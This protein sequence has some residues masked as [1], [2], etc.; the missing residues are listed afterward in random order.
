MLPDI[1]VTVLDNP[2][3]DPKLFTITVANTEDIWPGDQVVL[4]LP[5]LDIQTIAEAHPEDDDSWMPFSLLNSYTVF[6]TDI[7]GLETVTSVDVPIDYELENLKE[8]KFEIPEDTQ[9]GNYRVRGGYVW[10]MYGPV[11]WKKVTYYHK[12]KIPDITIEVKEAVP[13]QVHGVA[14][15]QSETLKN[16]LEEALGKGPDYTGELTVVELKTLTGALDLSGAGITDADMELMQYLIGVT[17]I[18]LSDNPDITP[19]T[20]KKATFDWTLEKSLD[21]SGCTGL[22][23]LS[24]RAFYGCAGLKGFVFPNTLTA[25]GEMC[26]AGCTGLTAV[27]LPPDLTNIGDYAFAGSAITQITIPGGV[28]D[29]GE[30]VFRFCENLQTVGLPANL[31]IIGDDCFAYCRGLSDIILSTSLTSIGANCFTQCESLTELILPDSLTTVGAYAFS[32]CPELPLINLPAALGTISNAAF[33]SQ[34]FKVVDGRQSHLTRD[35]LSLY[36]DTVFLTGDDAGID[37]PTAEIAAGQG[38]VTLTHQ[39]PATEI[40]VWG[41]SDTGIAEVENGVVTGVSGGTAY[42]YVKSTTDSHGGYCRVTVTDSGG[43]TLSALELSGIALNGTFDPLT[44]VYT[45][46]IAGDVRSTVVALQKSD[47]GSTVQ[48][49]DAAVTPGAAATVALDYP[50]SVIEIKVTSADTAVTKTYVITITMSPVT[51]KEDGR[52]AIGNPVLKDRLALAAGKEA[53]KYTEN[54]TVTEL[55]DITG[56][57]DLSSADLLDSDMAAMQ[58][59]TG[60]SAIDFSDNTGLTVIPSQDNFD[61]T[62]EKS[63]DFSGCIGV[64]GFHDGDTSAHSGFQGVANLTGIMLPETMSHISSA[65]FRDCTKLAHVV[66]PGALKSTGSRAFYGCSTLSRIDLPEG[67]ETLGDSCFAGTGLKSIVLPS[68]LISIGNQC[69]ADCEQLI[70][71]TIPA[72]VTEIKYGGFK[73]SGLALLDLRQTAFTETDTE[74]WSIP[75]TTLVVYPGSTSAGMNTSSA[76]LTV[77]EEGLTLSHTIPDG[78]TVVWSSTDEDVAVVSADGLVTGVGAG[79]AIILVSSEDGTYFDY[80]RVTFT[81]T[82][83][84]G[85]TDLFLTG[86]NLDQ[87]FDPQRVYYTAG[88]DY[89]TP[90][91][92]TATT[93]DPSSTITVNGS[94]VNS[95]T[96]SD[97]VDLSGGETTFTVAVTT[98]GRTRAYTIVV[99]LKA[100]YEA[101]TGVSIVNVAFMHSLA[102]AAGKGADYSGPLTY[103]ELAAIQFDL[104][105]S[106]LDLSDADMAVMKYLTN[107]TALDLSGNTAL[108]AASAT[109]AIFNWTMLG[110]INFRGCTGITEILD[111]AFEGYGYLSDMVLPE[112]LSSLG[113]SSFAGTGFVSITLPGSI[114]TLGREIFKDCIALAQAD[115]SRIPVT[116][117]ADAGIF[118]GGA[119]P[120]Q[121]WRTL[122]CLRGSP[123]C[124]WDYSTA[125][126]ASRPSTCPPASPSLATAFLPVRALPRRT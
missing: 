52:V 80:C 14:P 87:A 79:T 112:T 73:D 115:L 81:E 114:T 124:R 18:D 43:A 6:V 113:D 102:V 25:I 10:V 42:I 92:I 17:A 86:A 7:P 78:L 37:P 74:E 20:L 41:S 57:I 4:N 49:N 3:Y 39:I 28:T 34:Y 50:E 91:R 2:D 118:S 90:F 48:V 55:A 61:W 101:D 12:G 47:A 9:P 85:L 1:A 125:A 36:A 65:V 60:V 122:C 21:F 71:L 83:T 111:N 93:A 97:P 105:L 40:V 109:G 95:G 108:T 63:L 46:D 126:P 24:A 44:Y 59:L 88:G 121:I 99:S 51:E 68:S 94:A 70:H 19:E 45:A 13:G 96:P 119:L 107:V 33:N 30:G 84:P 53:G 26:F 15:I 64:E 110:S 22:T 27:T 104:D 23:E 62:T 116:A 35:D 11:W 66:L 72:S 31:A 29:L 103:D 82:E 32:L 120:S 75:D 69:F 77:G 56:A 16:R 67:L 38:T 76:E 100:V 117:L 5:D 123:P 98:D 54:L 58:Y 89:F 106:G 8:I